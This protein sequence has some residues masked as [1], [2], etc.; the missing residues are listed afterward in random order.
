[1]EG[2]AT[3]YLRT[4]GILH[5][6]RA[7]ARGGGVGVKTHPLSLI[8][9]KKFITRRVYEACFFTKIRGVWVEEYAYYVNKLRL[10]TWIWR[11]I[12]TSQTA[13][14][15]YKWPPSAT[16][17]NTPWKFSA[18]A[19]GIECWATII[20]RRQAVTVFNASF[21]VGGPLTAG[22]EACAPRAS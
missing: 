8:F 9:C 5:W 14:T 21:H 12:V 4:P 10:R 2:L 7:Y 3:H 13:H 22:A 17:W 15:K 6:T 19:T 11:Q 1:V 18:Y 20:V 16:E